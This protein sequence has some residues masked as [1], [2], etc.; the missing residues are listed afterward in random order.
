[1]SRP[2]ASTPTS[3][4]TDTRGGFGRAILVA[5]GATLVIL[6]VFVCFA[7][8]GVKSQPRSLPLGIAAPP[9]VA[10]QV[11]RG[12][13]TAQPD[14][15]AVHR[16]GDAA[17]VQ[18]AVRDREMYGGLALGPDGRPTMYVASGASPVVAQLLTQLGERLGTPPGQATPAPVQPAIVDLAPM[19]QDDP[20]GAG[21]AGAAL[22]MA[23]GGVIP[24]LIL[25]R[26]FPRQGRAQVV[27]AAAASALVGAGIAVILSA[28]FGTIPEAAAFWP[29]AGG[30][31][32]GVA[33]ITF[34]LLG[35]GA[36]AG[37]PG[38]ILG[39]LLILLIGNPLSGMASAPEMLPAGW[40]ALGQ[41]LPPGANAT[42]LRSTVFFDGA[43]G[44]PAT[45]TLV[46]YLVGGL[47]LL[48][49]GASV[50]RRRLARAER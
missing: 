28:W 50:S 15:F 18:A 22:P 8:P 7:L 9:P 16:Y 43:G 26:L 35:L 19:T 37:M 30:L 3:E 49:V 23:L 20:R 6:A 33:A 48:A 25:F 5:V 41:A 27:G 21:L 24:A 13:A 32:L 45:L 17:A 47:I 29:I 40:G 39:V 34:A 38:L 2:H 12:L 4:P 14:A 36:V 46:A 31:A 11:E 44:G 1:M 10:M 42:L